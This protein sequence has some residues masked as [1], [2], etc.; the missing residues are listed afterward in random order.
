MKKKINPI[1]M[2]KV[3]EAVNQEQATK[4]TKSD[5]I[6]QQIQRGFDIAKRLNPDKIIDEEE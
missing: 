1:V 6:K 5:K 2:K 4:L 3:L